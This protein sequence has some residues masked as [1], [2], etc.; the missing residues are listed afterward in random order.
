MTHERKRPPEKSGE[1]VDMAPTQAEQRQ[2]DLSSDAAPE[3]AGRVA[4]IPS[5]D[6][7]KPKA[8]SA[9]KSSSARPALDSKY[10]SMSE[11]DIDL[12]DYQMMDEVMIYGL[13]CE[14]ELQQYVQLAQ[15][16]L[17]QG[18]DRVL[19]DEYQQ[20]SRDLLRA[21]NELYDQEAEEVFDEATLVLEEDAP[22]IFMDA[23]RKLQKEARQLF[24]KLD[25]NKFTEMREQEQREVQELSAS[26]QESVAEILA[27]YDGFETV[28]NKEPTQ[29][30]FASQMQKCVDMLSS[31][32][33]HQE[34][35]D[36]VKSFV[37]QVDGFQVKEER[38]ERIRRRHRKS[39]TLSQAWGTKR[40]RGEE[41][42]RRDD[43]ERKRGQIGE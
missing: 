10:F 26:I 12:P 4:E 30:Y 8:S 16:K 3:F 34:K 18:G 33:G 24:D 7:L 11:E 29:I 5:P 42:T 1:Q 41:R 31:S 15:D 40:K 14:K 25:P 32:R 37:K 28:M 17:L 43:L 6:T 23:M 2:V 36:Y 9:E 27:W 35:L 20:W 19:N 39:E 22:K 13:D 21:F 38:E